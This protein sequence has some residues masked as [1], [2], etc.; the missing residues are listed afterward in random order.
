MKVKATRKICHNATA[1]NTTFNFIDK[2]LACLKWNSSKIQ[3]RPNLAAACLDC[4]SGTIGILS[5]C[6]I[7]CQMQ[8]LVGEWWIMIQ[9]SANYWKMRWGPLTENRCFKCLHV[10]SHHQY[11]VIIKSIYTWYC[12]FRFKYNITL[13]FLNMSQLF[14]MR[15]SIQMYSVFDK[16]NDGS[17]SS[18][19]TALRW[20]ARRWPGYLHILATTKNNV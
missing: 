11:I 19:Q 17:K 15:W 4:S 2:V 9:V 7:T 1:I 16:C 6:C 14:V 8:C 12:Y 5:N 20:L 10:N 18:K 13:A 3:T